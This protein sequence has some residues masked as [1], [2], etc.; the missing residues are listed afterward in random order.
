[1]KQLRYIFLHLFLLSVGLNYI[2]A[3][4]N[5]TFRSNLKYPGQTCANIWGYVD[6]LGNEY[7]L[8]GASKG[9]SIVNVTNPDV[10]V[11][12]IQVPGPDNLWKEME[13]FEHYAYV[14]SEGGSGLQIIDLRSL[15]DTNGIKYHYWQP[16]INGGTLNT[17]HSLHIDTLKKFVYVYGS[18]INNGS[19]VVGDLSIDPYNPTYAG[20][21]IK[22]GT[23]TITY[24]HDGYV[25]NDTLYS[26]NIYNGMVTIVD[27]RN[28]ISPVML[29]SFST[30]KSATHNT[31]LSDNSKTLF[32]T[33]ETTASSLTAYDISNI[34]KPTQVDMIQSNQAGGSIVHNCHVKSDWVVCSYYRDGV[35]VFDGHRPSNLVQ[36]ADYDTY[37]AASGAGY[38]GAW[39]V[40][41]FLPSGNLVVSNIEDGLFVLSPTY[42]RACYLEGIVTDSVTG[43]TINT[44]NVV[45]QTTNVIDSTKLTG[46]YAVG[47]VTPGVYTVQVSKSGY[48]TRLIGGI[49]L[50]A[51]NVTNLN[52]KLKPISSSVHDMD[53]I[54]MFN[55]YPNPFT[56]SF[57]IAYSFNE[58]LKANTCLLLTDITG[59]T[60]IQQAIKNRSGVITIDE[61]LERGV[62]FIRLL[63]ASNTSSAIK[64]MKVE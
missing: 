16:V 42:N 64:I 30:P 32:T 12:V 52:V 10:P 41:P 53:G 37:P 8:V 6:S 17:I 22:A 4:Q 31:W 28:K 54:N 49:T 48:I 43:W 24:V 60:V 63:N 7:A 50:S 2:I 59:R 13:V 27:F 11:H 62:Y 21:Y 20:T 26:A 47:T 3:Q 1:M 55:V 14:T 19:A 51:G 23:K 45:I 38:N 40:Y 33:D 29:K 15:P 9:L 57:S 18:N 44:A 39:G 35:V 34:T 36:V 46:D 5:I 58:E 25:R 61:V 56:N